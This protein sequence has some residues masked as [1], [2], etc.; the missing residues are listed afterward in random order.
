MRMMMITMMIDDDDEN[1][2]EADGIIDDRGGDC[3]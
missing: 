1:D 2:Y 3:S